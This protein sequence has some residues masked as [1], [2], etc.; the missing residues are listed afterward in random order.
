MLQPVRSPLRH[1]QKA[2]GGSEGAF[3]EKAP[4]VMG[5]AGQSNRGGERDTVLPT[6]LHFA[7]PSVRIGTVMRSD[8]DGSPNTS[9]PAS[10]ASVAP[11]I[12]FLKGGN[13]AGPPPRA[14]IRGGVFLSTQEHE[15]VATVGVAAPLFSL[16]YKGAGNPA[17]TKAGVAGISLPRGTRNLSPPADIL[18]VMRSASKRKSR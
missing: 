7:E 17:T 11:K 13:G 5:Q 3:H 12:S 4:P 16:S 2:G 9:P 8:R 18:P 15:A 6:R 1:S 14:R 10:V